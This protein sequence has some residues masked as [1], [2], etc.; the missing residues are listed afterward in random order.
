MPSVQ[1]PVSVNIP[2]PPI[3][4]AV[5]SLIPGVFSGSG[6]LTRPF[7][8]VGVDAL[9]ISWSFITVPAGIGFVLGDPRHYEVRMLQLSVEH[10][11]LGTNSFLSEF[12]DFDVE[13][14]YLMFANP[15]PDAVHYNIAP[16]VTLVFYWLLV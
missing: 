14:I 12:H 10:H 11:D 13:G 15:F 1:V 9:G 8:G 5:R 16:G 3:T 6:V 7:G 2:V 4:F